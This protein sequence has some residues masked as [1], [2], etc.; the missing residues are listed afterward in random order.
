MLSYEHE[1]IISL[2]KHL[3]ASVNYKMLSDLYEIKKDH[4]FESQPQLT[5]ETSS[6]LSMIAK[7]LNV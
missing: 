7:I 1:M 3:Y 6:H 2:L 4:S 5:A